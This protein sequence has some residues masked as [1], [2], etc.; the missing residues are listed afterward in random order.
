MRFVFCDVNLSEVKGMEPS[1]EFEA[2]G[3]TG[4]RESKGSPV[5]HSTG[6]AK[7]EEKNCD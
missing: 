2:I 1:P 4:S 7:T 3:E 6:V 5:I